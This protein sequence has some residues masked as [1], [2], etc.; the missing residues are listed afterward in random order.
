MGVTICFHKP[1][2]AL[3]VYIDLV[4]LKCI[5]THKKQTRTHICMCI[6]ECVLHAAC[7]VCERQHA[8][9][10]FGIKA[11]RCKIPLSQAL[12]KRDN[13]LVMLYHVASHI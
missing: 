12:R 10:V 2:E 4:L 8:Q 6:C 9:A 7:C 5:S 1:T 13:A 11:P 3:S